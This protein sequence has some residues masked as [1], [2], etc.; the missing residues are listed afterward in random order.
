MFP[1]ALRRS[2]RLYPDKIA[3]ATTNERLIYREADTRGNRLANAL[4]GLGLN[5]GDRIALLVGNSVHYWELYFGI[6]RAGFACVPINTHLTAAE[7]GFILTDSGATTLIYDGARAGLVEEMGG[8]TL[9][10][11]VRHLIAIDKKGSDARAYEELLSDAAGTPPALEVNQESASLL[12]YT[13]GTTGQPKGVVL[14]HRA[15]FGDGLSQ[16]LGHYQR[17]DDR[18]ITATPLYHLAAAARVHAVAIAGGTQLVL[19]DFDPELLLTFAEKE[20]AT[21]TL[22][23][24]TM[25]R[26]ILEVLETRSFDLSSLRSVVHGAAP[27]PFEVLV[28]IC[29]RLPVGHYVGWGLTEGG[30]F[31]TS[32]HPDDYRDPDGKINRRL[33]SVGR[34]A[35]NAEVI[36][37]DDDGKVVTGTGERGELVV[38][39]DRMMTGYW[40]Q[41]DNTAEVLRDGWLHTGDVAHA[42]DEGF[43]Y[44]VDR[45]KEMIISGGVNIYP[46]EIEKVLEAH[47]G[48]LEVAVIGVPDKKWG[49]TPMA[50]VVPRPGH[51]LQEEELVAFAKHSL[52]GFKVPR[53]VRIVDR[54]P[55]NS[56]GKVA[57]SEL[58]KEHWQG[59]EKQVN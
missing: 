38:R 17:H 37:I 35:V 44:I 31:L 4:R 5:A 9:L 18:F 12:V 54:L 20:R 16:V 57:K 19:E 40:N 15:L 33:T 7:A 26:R 34:E 24:A 51:H 29:E 28:A 47:P 21:S 14:S 25:A 23:V 45:K 30:T 49:E 22:M 10:A 8:A 39:S 43:L 52:A 13:S 11:G 36:L 1:D 42:D 48:V 55:R 56:V 32:L 3:V 41:P 53:Q 59:Y 27:T 46:L 58:R 6:A 2:A 50:V